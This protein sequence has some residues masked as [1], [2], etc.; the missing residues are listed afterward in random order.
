VGPVRHGHRG[1]LSR[2]TA[3]PGPVNNRR[4]YGRA[5]SELRAPIRYPRGLGP[6]TPPFTK[7]STPAQKPSAL[8]LKSSTETGSRPK[9]AGPQESYTA[10]NSRAKHVLSRP[11]TRRRPHPSGAARR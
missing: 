9:P 11:P 10:R 4:P 1:G 6:P 3:R 5:S 7:T 8:R 2:R